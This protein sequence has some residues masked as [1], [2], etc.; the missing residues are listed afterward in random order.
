MWTDTMVSLCKTLAKEGCSAG[1]IAAAL[2]TKTRNAVMGKLHREKI[3]LTNK[4]DATIK[5]NKGRAAPLGWFPK[6]QNTPCATLP[7]Q[8]V[9]VSR[10]EGFS[11]RD[12]NDD[13]CRWPFGER[14]NMYFCGRSKF[15]G[16]SYCV[17]HHWQSH[18]HPK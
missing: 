17:H 11:F 15:N 5:S 2:G 3:H 9:D 14:D 18:W 7:L 13:Q 16:S 10:E 4:R 12:L 1:Q 6:T 8:K